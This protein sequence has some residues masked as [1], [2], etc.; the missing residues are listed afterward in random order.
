MYGCL[1]L[2][3]Y[4]GG[5]TLIFVEH[6]RYIYQVFYDNPLHFLSLTFCPTTDPPAP[7]LAAVAE[8]VNGWCD[9]R[10]YSMLRINAYIHFF[11]M[12]NYNIHA[13]FWAFLSF[14][15]LV[16]IYRSFI[17]YFPTSKLVLYLSIFCV[18]SI[19]FWGSGVHKEGLCYFLLGLSWY[20]FTA[21]QSHKKSIYYLFLILN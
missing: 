2:Y 17:S 9:M 14:T 21:I 6:S 8:Q 3:Y 5:D 1:H 19:V 10:F 16:G 11:S 7:H 20:Y 15:G 13:I 18:P 12:G 4:N